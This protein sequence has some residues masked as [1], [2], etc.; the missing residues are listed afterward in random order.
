MRQTRRLTKPVLVLL[1]FLALCGA[2]VLAQQIQLSAEAYLTPPKEI[3]DAV[4]AAQRDHVLL[5]NLS[6]DGRKFL[7]TKSDGPPT[8]ARLACPCVYLAE[9]AFDPVACRAR[10]L[11]V[12]SDIG[13]DLVYHAD[14]RTVPVQV[15]P[16]ARVSNALWSPDGARLAFFAHFPEATHICLADTE[17]G[18]S[19]RL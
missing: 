14:N 16:G 2:P 12:R 18:Y 7:I 17:T 5:T 6:P 10:Q 4:V 11:W 1:A 8:L 15:P 19:R 3:H 13:Y 9:M